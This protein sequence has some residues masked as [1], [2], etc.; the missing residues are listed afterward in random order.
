MTVEICIKLPTFASDLTWTKHVLE[1]CVKAKRLPGAV[2][3]SGGK[4]DTLKTRLIMYL[5]VI[6][7]V[8]GYAC[9]SSMVSPD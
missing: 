4:I 3:R 5:S 1:R 8:L 9:N 2:R 6:R 7:T